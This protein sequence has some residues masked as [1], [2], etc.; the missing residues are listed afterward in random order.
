[1]DY[2]IS[3]THFNHEKILYFDKSR[4]ESLKL[5]GIAPT[6][7]EMDR[8]LEKIW[9]DT[10][11]DEDTVYF[12]GDLGMFRKKQDF[13]AQLAR[14]R[15]KKILFKGNHDHTDQLKAAYKAPEAQVIEV[16]E[17]AKS[18]KID[19]RQV[20]L[21]HYAVD[22]PYPLLSLHG[23]IHEAEYQRDNMIN[24]SLDSPYM[25]TRVFGQPISFEALSPL[26]SER[27]AAI[28]ETYQTESENKR[29]D[30]LVERAFDEK[31]TINKPTATQR[32][33][34][35]L[36]V[37]YLNKNNLTYATVLKQFNI[38]NDNKV[39]SE[40]EKEKVNLTG[41]EFEKQTGMSGNTGIKDD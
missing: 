20:W 2:I 21:S 9:N 18:L 40:K 14:L 27:I 5:L 24:L 23:H 12:L 36:L 19:G 26:L 10:V 38:P 39:L 25:Q 32:H 17:T 30:R 37:D 35:A 28:S 33:E 4:A 41:F 22:L 1:M 11:T 16:V 6:I 15:G 29:Y 8:Y 7:S 31:I 13:V 3:D 34:L